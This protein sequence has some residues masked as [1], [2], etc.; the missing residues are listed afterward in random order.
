MVQAVHW[1]Q[2]RPYT[3]RALGPTQDEGNIKSG[4]HSNTNQHPIYRKKRGVSSKMP[5][6]RAFQNFDRQDSVCEG[7]QTHPGGTSTWL[8][9]SW[10]P[11]AKSCMWRSYFTSHEIPQLSHACDVHTSKWSTSVINKCLQETET[12]GTLKSSHLA[13]AR[14]ASRG[15]NKEGL[16]PFVL[17][18]TLW[19]FSVL[20]QQAVKPQCVS[21]SLLQVVGQTW[22]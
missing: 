21:P 14:L 17:I 2:R 18:S 20:L 11:T 6:K 19:H 22:L 9:Q 16:V 10:D 4:T 3:Y 1:P 5:Q 8:H 7:E 12:G 13:E 15:W